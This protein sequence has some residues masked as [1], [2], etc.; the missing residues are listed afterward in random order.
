MNERD[1]AAIPRHVGF[2]LDGNRRWAKAQGK[3]A[4]FGHEAGYRTVRPIVRHA[5]ERGVSFVS[6]YA[7]S[8]ENWSRAQDEID[9][10]MSLFIRFARKEGEGFAK[11]GIRVVVLGRRAGLSAEVASAVDD[12][13]AMTAK[14]TRGTVALCF[15]Y[16][17]REE[18]EDAALLQHEAGGTGKLGDYI[19]SPE[20]PDIDVVI[21]TSGEQRLSGFM[22]WRASYAE[23]VFSAKPWP[24]FK[25]T[26]LDDALEEFARR[27]RR[28]GG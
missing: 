12:L 3:P 1:S 4:A 23:F 13:V 17:G 19:Y 2:I 11:E 24:E 8:I 5:F 16:G 20:V 14:G 7:F 10:L 22:L 21:R 18:L 15:N 28:F 27:Q 6:L 9:F 25:P 26:D